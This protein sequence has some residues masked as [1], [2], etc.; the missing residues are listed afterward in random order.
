MSRTLQVNTLIGSYADGTD[1]YPVIRTTLAASLSSVGI[2][3]T[4]LPNIYLIGVTGVA[5][6][7]ISLQVSE[8]SKIAAMP[9]NTNQYSFD[10]GV[11]NDNINIPIDKLVLITDTPSASTNVRLNYFYTPY[12][13]Q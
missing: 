13:L 11:Y 8:I 2:T 5:T 3:G 7:G 6:S 4:G 12:V 1:L 9:Y 10:I